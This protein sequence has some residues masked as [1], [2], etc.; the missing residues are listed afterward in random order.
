MMAGRG[1]AS[2]IS[3]ERGEREREE[4]ANTMIRRG[5]RIGGGASKSTTAGEE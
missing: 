1:W 5:H 4:R 3:R 2:Y